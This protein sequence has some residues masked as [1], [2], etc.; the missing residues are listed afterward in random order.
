MIHSDR[1]V[2]AFTGINSLKLLERIVQA[3]QLLQ[4]PEWRCKLQLDLT[5]RIVLTMVKIKLNVSLTAIAILFAISVTTCT[6][7]F[8]MTVELL[9]RVLKTA[10]LWPSKEDILRNMPVCFNKFKKTRVVLDCSEV[11]VETPSCLKCRLSTYS[12]Y[13]GT[14]T[15]KFLVGVA[16]DGLITFLSEVYGG[17]A[18]DKAITLQSGIIETV[19]AHSDAIMVDKGFLI[20]H[21]CI[22]NAIQLIRP[23]FLGKRKQFPQSE[24]IMTADIASARVHVERAIQRIKVFKLLKTNVPW[25]LVPYLDDILVIVGGLVNLSKPILALDKF[26]CT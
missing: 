12:H 17:R 6:S 13:K 4:A 8:Y 19:D 20:E 3:A 11:S 1:D 10:V 23:P 7:Y 22:F 14:N 15:M 9:S 5:E 26:E 25:G 21:E 2:N 18:S 24:G 16:P